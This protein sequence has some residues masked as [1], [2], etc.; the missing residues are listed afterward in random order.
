MSEPPARCAACGRDFED[1]PVNPAANPA[2]RN[3]NPPEPQNFAERGLQ[4]HN[5]LLAALSAQLESL[6]A[7]L[8]A[9]MAEDGELR[10]LLARLR[11]NLRPR[12]GLCIDGNCVLCRVQEAAIKEHV[13]AYIEWKVPGTTQKLRQA[14]QGN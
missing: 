14:R 10:D 3:P 2:A 8:A 1:R 6:P 9:G 12:H 5:R 13:V 4:E 11:D 7:R